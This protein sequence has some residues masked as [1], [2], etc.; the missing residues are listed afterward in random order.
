MKGS[1]AQEHEALRRR[2]SARPPSPEVRQDCPDPAD[3]YEATSGELAIEARQ[4]IVD[5]L[6]VCAECAT[7]W[8]LA[9][10]L[11]AADRAAGATPRSPAV[12]PWMSMLAA[13]AGVVLTAGV[14]FLTM[15]ATP[16][17][18]PVYRDGGGIARPV[19]LL[20]GTSLPRTDFRLR[21]TA[22]PPGARY[23]VRVT[24]STLEPVFVRHDLADAEVHAPPAVFAGMKSGTQLFWQVEMRL[25]EGETVSSSSQLVELE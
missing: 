16:P 13:A 21:W 19:S 25:P 14:V 22:G 9:V 11:R 10:E 18:A 1:V 7:A 24:D 3:L 2:F 17:E 23:T 8:R 6:T 15:Q 12:R 20:E 4:R 5:H